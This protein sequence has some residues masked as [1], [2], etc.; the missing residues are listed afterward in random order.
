MRFAYK[1]LLVAV[2]LVVLVGVASAVFVMAGDNAKSGITEKGAEGPKPLAANPATTKVEDADDEDD[3]QDEVEEEQEGEHQDGDENEVKVTLDQVPP[4]VKD[5]I[6]N[7]AGSNPIKE[8]EAETKGGKTVYEAEWVVAGQEIEIKVAADGTIL[9]R[10]VE[11]E[12]D[13]EKDEK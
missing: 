9:K 3:D 1:L 13:D 11:K 5:A 2:A 12:D 8:I 4:A 6:L 10:K 7:E